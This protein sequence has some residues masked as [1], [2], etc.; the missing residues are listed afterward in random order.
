MAKPDEP[1]RGDRRPD[2]ERAAGPWE[3]VERL[4]AMWTAGTLDGL[5]GLFAPDAVF[6]AAGAAAR[7]DGREAIVASF[8]EYL[9]MAR[10]LEFEVRDRQVVEDGDHA[11]ICYGFDVRYELDGAVHS[12]S[13]QEVLVLR[14]GEGGWQV[15]WRN[16][17]TWPA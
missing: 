13:G 15:R 12:E 4:N 3:A 10:T 14:R 17:V 8:A 1:A 11:V 2:H 6:V 16:Q 9:G 5:A 7:L